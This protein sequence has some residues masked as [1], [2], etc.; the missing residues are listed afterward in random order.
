MRKTLPLLTLLSLLLFAS[1]AMSGIIT[2][3]LL[4]KLEETED[5]EHI[6]VY[7]VMEQ[8]ADVHYLMELV[9]GKQLKERRQLVIQHLKELRDNSQGEILSYLKTM[10]AQGKIER[11]R[12]LWLTNMV[13]FSGEKK[14]IEAVS[15]LPGVAHID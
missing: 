12:S 7:V 15:R 4:E 6:R 11:L 5:N 8:Q 14:I 2:E 13:C 10:E 3:P 1:S 9:R